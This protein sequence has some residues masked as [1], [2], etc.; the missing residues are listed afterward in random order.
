MS[1]RVRVESRD[2]LITLNI[3]SAVP[4]DSGVYRILVRNPVSEITSSCTLNVY[5]TNQATATAP[6]FTNSIKGMSFGVIMNGTCVLHFVYFLIT[7]E[8]SSNY[9]ILNVANFHNAQ[10][11]CVCVCVF[12]SLSLLLKIYN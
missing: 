9:T 4:E 6:L 12:F 11:A 2:G 7:F 10:N 1:P 8:V 3:Q 5:Q